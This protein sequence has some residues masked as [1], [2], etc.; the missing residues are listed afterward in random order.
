VGELRD[1]QPHTMYYKEEPSVSLTGGEVLI[2]EEISQYQ[3]AQPIVLPP[4][5]GQGLGSTTTPNNGQGGGTGPHVGTGGGAEASGHSGLTLRLTVPKG[6]VASLMGVMNL[7]QSR[8]STMQVTLH[9]ADGQLSEQEYEDKVME[10]FRQM[11]V[12]VEIEKGT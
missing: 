3:V 6:K 4:D 2:R 12:D 5:G 10:T 7:L 8:F 11:G 9:V 1:G